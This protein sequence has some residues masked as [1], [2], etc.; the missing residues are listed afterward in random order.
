MKDEIEYRDP[1]EDEDFKRILDDMGA[2]FEGFSDRLHAAGTSEIQEEVVRVKKEYEAKYE[3]LKARM[4]K[5]LVN[6]QY[7][8]STLH[9]KKTGAK[10]G[11]NYLGTDI[12]ESIYL[13]GWQTLPMFERKL[14]KKYQL[15]IRGGDGYQIADLVVALDM[16]YLVYLWYGFLEQ[17]PKS[18]KDW[19]RIVSLIQRVNAINI[20][21]NLTSNLLAKT[22]Y[23]IT[24]H[25]DKKL[26]ESLLKAPIPDGIDFKNLKAPFA[27]FTLK[28]PTGKFTLTSLDNLQMFTLTKQIDLAKVKTEQVISWGGQQFIE[29]T[30][31]DPGMEIPIKF[32]LLYNSTNVIFKKTEHFSRDDFGERKVDYNYVP[33]T[34]LRIPKTKYIDTGDKEKK[35]SEFKGIH[36]KPF[37][38]SA[39]WHKFWKTEQNATAANETI[40]DTDDKSGRGLVAVVKFIEPFWKGPDIGKIVAMNDVAAMERK[41]VAAR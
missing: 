2:F 14:A 37:L 3:P 30:I 31:A 26:Y 1:G 29:E 8:T 19:M 39:H 41:V 16:E 20:P 10:V 12:F 13:K 34:I 28:L 4:I 36:T 24:Y 18:Q 6:M 32:L 40:I 33:Q 22:S 25:I 7:T 35:S 9:I 17:F 23:R 15:H 27:A 11:E 21:A 5:C 38:V